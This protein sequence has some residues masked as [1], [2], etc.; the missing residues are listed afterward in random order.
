M[1]SVRAS[2]QEFR[3]VKEIPLC[4]FSPLEP[5]LRKRMVVEIIEDLQELDSHRISS[6]RS[7]LLILPEKKLRYRRLKPQVADHG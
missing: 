4:S 3:N 2:C 6:C 5:L 7:H 1:P